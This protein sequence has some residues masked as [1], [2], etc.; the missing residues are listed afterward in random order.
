[1]NDKGTTGIISGAS[2]RLPAKELRLSSSFKA[3]VDS[4]VNG[5]NTPTS[6]LLGRA[7]DIISRSV[8]SGDIL[9]SPRD[10]TLDGSETPVGGAKLRS[11]LSLRRH[12][13]N[14]VPSSSAVT[15]GR[16]GLQNAEHKGLHWKPELVTSSTADQRSEA[17]E[18]QAKYLKLQADLKDS[19]AANAMLQRQLHRVQEAMVQSRDDMEN[20]QRLALAAKEQADAA[21]SRAAAAE[22]KAEALAAQVVN[23]EQSCASSDTGQAT[24]HKH[25]KVE[26]APAVGPVPRPSN[27][28]QQACN[29]LHIQSSSW[30]GFASQASCASGL[31]SAGCPQ[32]IGS[33]SPEAKDHQGCSTLSWAA[34]PDSPTSPAAQPAPGMQGQGLPSEY[35]GGTGHCGMQVWSEAQ[36]TSNMNR[37]T[38]HNFLQTATTGIDRHAA[39][40][41]WHNA[42]F[43]S[44]APQGRDSTIGVRASKPAG[45]TWQVQ[46]SQPVASKHASQTAGGRGHFGLGV[47][48]E[49]LAALERAAKAQHTWAQITLQS[50]PEMQQ[51]HG[52]L[53]SAIV[54]ETLNRQ[55]QAQLLH[56]SHEGYPDLQASGRQEKEQPGRRTSPRKETAVASASESSSGSPSGSPTSD[57]TGWAGVFATAL[58]AQLARQATPMLAVV[59]SAQS[60]CAIRLKPLFTEA[61]VLTHV[62]SLQEKREQLKTGTGGNMLQD[63]SNFY[64]FRQC[65]PHKPAAAAGPLS[66]AHWSYPSAEPSSDALLDP[67]EQPASAVSPAVAPAAPGLEWPAAVLWSQAGPA[68]LAEALKQRRRLPVELPEE[69]P[70]LLPFDVP[71]P[72]PPQLQPAQLLG[73]LLRLPVEYFPAEGAAFKIALLFEGLGFVGSGYCQR[74]GSARAHREHHFSQFFA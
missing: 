11:C 21:E 65:T 62:L 67:S 56:L 37:T 19:A 70:W 30:P 33:I 48:T 57:S 42:A 24:E 34:Y 60:V 23:L 3:F 51:N 8:N 36:L 27:V 9:H 53:S 59:N 61:H 10:S 38:A 68:L 14:P 46:G 55:R 26:V 28:L 66:H 12:S 71:T 41:S 45:Q 73:A 69:Q 74:L 44:A 40:H 47:H 64:L 58:T 15:A 25:S 17:R 13:D 4:A 35:F 63:S 20:A 22:T 50:K 6:T 32:S 49:S 18:L 54:I 5:Q 1:M 29:T 2:T 7:S 43:Q 31:P 72:L 39:G 16:D 52:F